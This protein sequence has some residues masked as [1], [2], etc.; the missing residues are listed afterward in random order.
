MELLNTILILT[1]CESAKQLKNLPP[2][3]KQRLAHAL[4]ERVPSDL[5]SIEEWN[6]L[7]KLFMDAPPEQ[8]NKIAKSKLLCC[9]C[10]E[11]YTEVSAVNHNPNQWQFKKKR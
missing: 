2:D 7:L 10:G 8:D 11:P 6:E 1:K 9:L 4:A 5:A 3:R